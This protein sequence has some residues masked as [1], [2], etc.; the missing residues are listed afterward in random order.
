M[1][2][3]KQ[4]FSVDGFNEGSRQKKEKREIMSESGRE[5]EQS[6]LCKTGEKKKLETKKEIAVCS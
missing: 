5:V 1:R 6:G 2:E 4:R 3:E